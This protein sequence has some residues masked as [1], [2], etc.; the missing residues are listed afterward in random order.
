MGGDQLKTW[1]KF[2]DHRGMYPKGSNVNYSHVSNANIKKIK[3]RYQLT[4]VMD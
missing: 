1:E 3:F 2:I 4:E